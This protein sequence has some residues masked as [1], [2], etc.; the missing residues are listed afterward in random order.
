MAVN[1]SATTDFE[2]DNLLGNDANG[3]GCDPTLSG[4]D[5]TQG[6]GA[7]TIVFNGTTIT[8]TTSG[9]SATITITGYTVL[10]GDVG[11]TVNITGGT[12]FTPG[13]Y[14]IT[15]VNTGTNTWTL[16]ATCSTAAA[17]GMTGRAGGSLATYAQSLASNSGGRDTYLHN[18]GTAYT[19]A[20]T[21][22]FISA[23]NGSLIGYSTTRAKYNLDTRPQLKPSANSVT[24][25]KP[26]TGAQGVFNIDFVNPGAFTGCTGIDGFAAT[27][28]SLFVFNCRV[29]AYA[30]GITTYNISQVVCSETLNCTTSGIT[31]GAYCVIAFS[32][33]I[34]CP[35]G[36]L[37]GTRPCTALF[38]VV[39]GNAASG[40]NGGFESF[41]L[42][43][44]C[45]TWGSDG[46]GGFGFGTLGLGLNCLAENSAQKG[47]TGSTSVVD[48]H[49]TGLVSCA[50]HG[51]TADYDAQFTARNLL[52]FQALTGE[53]L[54]APAATSAANFAPNATSGAGLALRG[55][56]V[57]GQTFPSLASTPFYLDGGAVQHQDA[58]AGSIFA[59]A[60]L[61][62]KLNASVNSDRGGMPLYGSQTEIG[63]NLVTGNVNY[64]ASLT[65]QALTVGF[66]A[67]NLRSIFLWSDKGLTIKANSTSSPTYTITLKPQSPL[68]WS[69]SEGYFPCPLSD[70]TVWYITTTVGTTL[71]YKLLSI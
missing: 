18:N 45:T 35:G 68:V 25:F 33:S 19:L 8:A 49:L 53:A 30:I 15:S 27:I 23:T 50:G 67:A 29:T 48:K 31:L 70:T 40:S 36:I 21:T 13:L 11:N 34:N 6:A 17:S 54:T 41:S 69:V 7:K 20:A 26:T 51:N 2:V 58:G 47:Y 62:Q 65:N 57:L 71:Q 16:Q 5:Y 22:A 46:T 37:A 39:G 66:T 32:N 59:L 24:A 3:G 64:G 60:G 14:L 9:A 52:G 43:I 61:N 4:T 12:N 10:A 38:C 63:S 44:N 42:C 55:L 56:G 1:I 28:N